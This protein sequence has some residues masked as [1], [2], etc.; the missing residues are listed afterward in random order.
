MSGRGAHTKKSGALRTRRE[1]DAA[2]EDFPADSEKPPIKETLK[3]DLNHEWTRMDTNGH[4]W[5]RMDTNGHE[6]TRMDTNGNRPSR[7]EFVW[8]RVHSW[9]NQRF[10]KKSIGGFSESVGALAHPRSGV[11]AAARPTRPVLGI[12]TPIAHAPVRPCLGGTVEARVGT[13][14]KRCPTFLG[15]VIRVNPCP[16]VVPVAW[17]AKVFASSADK[18]GGQ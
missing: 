15:A 18:G 13:G 7:L 2:S 8:V 17:P 9:L 5:T 12:L 11:R 10:L 3:N 14:W 4:E 1:D 6:W 16:S